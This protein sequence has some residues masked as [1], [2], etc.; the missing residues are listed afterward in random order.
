MMASEGSFRIPLSDPELEENW[1]EFLSS[2]GDYFN[3]TIR[4]LGGTNYQVHD[5]DDLCGLLD[6]LNSDEFWDDML[7]ADT[8]ANL[9]RQPKQAPQVSL[10]CSF[11][12][13]L[14]LVITITHSCRNL[15]LVLPN[16]PSPK[17]RVL[18]WKQWQS[19]A[20]VMNASMKDKRN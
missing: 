15:F 18:A 12:P 13:H 16:T 8:Q 7:S 14:T 10:N 6:S 19:A 17:E 9:A 1:H 2:Q 11:I 5:S 20:T 4:Q 3:T